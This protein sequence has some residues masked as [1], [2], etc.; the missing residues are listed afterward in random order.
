MFDLLFIISL[1]LISLF[2]FRVVES[3]NKEFP[4][5]R[6]VCGSMGW[7]TYSV[8]DPDV[9]QEM[10]GHTVKLIDGLPRQL[11][12]TNLSKSACLGVLG[13]PGLTAYLALTE[14]CRAKAGETVVISSAAGQIGHL[15][16]QIAKLLGLK[17][18][19]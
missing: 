18:I 16:G 12:W 15:A 10:C 17:V 6:L 11:D 4:K 5:G 2:F 1:L 19:G 3:K 8:V 13:I 7:Q 14:A 9:T